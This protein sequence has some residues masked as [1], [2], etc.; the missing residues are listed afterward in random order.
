MSIILN[1]ISTNSI[2]LSEGLQRLLIIANKTNNAEL[3][4]WCSKE[5]SGYKQNDEIP[6]YRKFKS[7]NIVYSGIVGRLTIT[8]QPLQ[9]GYL[10]QKTLK[11]IEDVVL[12]ENIEEVE[13]RKELKSPL[14]RDL[15]PLAG[16]V[17]QNTRNGYPGTGV[18]CVSIQQQITTEFYSNIFTAVKIRII[19]L[20]CYFES[21][22]V[23]LDNLDVSI[24]KYHEHNDALI[25]NKIVIDGQ[26]IVPQKEEKK[27]IWHIVVPIITAIIGSVVS[28]VLVYLITNVWM[29]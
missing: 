10:S 23:D 13:K 7:R 6:E 29:R 5:L 27:V 20:L 3:S 12:F 28:G 17:Y 2:S 26:T 4:E 9:Q 14:L 22:G 15:T 1:D 25:F 19:N 24:K 11:E 21:N 8:N 18:Q 16:E